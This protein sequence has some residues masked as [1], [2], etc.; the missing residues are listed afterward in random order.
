MKLNL[1]YIYVSIFKIL[2]KANFFT[3]FSTTVGS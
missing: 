2:A 3:N 1:Q